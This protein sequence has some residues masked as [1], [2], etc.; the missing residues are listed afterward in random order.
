MKTKSG[1]LCYTTALSVSLSLPHTDNPRKEDH[2]I[3]THTVVA[4]IGAEALAPNM[5]R[6]GTPW[7]RWVKHM[8]TVYNE[9]PPLRRRKRLI[10]NISVDWR[11][12]GD[13]KATVTGALD[14]VYDCIDDVA[15]LHRGLTAEEWT[16]P[17]EEEQTYR[18]YM[19][20]MDAA[21][22]SIEV[23]I[24]LQYRLG[25]AIYPGPSLY[26]AS[27]LR[28]LWLENREAVQVRLR[29]LTPDA[30]QVGVIGDDTQLEQLAAQR[31]ALALQQTPEEMLLARDG[32]NGGW[33]LGSGGQ[34]HV[35]LW[36][37]VTRGGQVVERMAVKDI[38]LSATDWTSAAA[39][40]GNV[41]DIEDRVPTEV[42]AMRVLRDEAHSDKTVS[43]VEWA[44]HWSNRMYRI[45]MEFC[46]YMTL[47]DV[48]GFNKVRQDEFPEEFERVDDNLDNIKLPEPF[49]WHCFESLV[50]AATS[51]ECKNTN[52]VSLEGKK[53]IVHRDIKPGNIFLGERSVETFAPYP[54][55]K[56]G[57]FGLCLFTSDDD[58]F[59]PSGYV[60]LGTTGFMAPEHLHTY[61]AAVDDLGR[62]RD[63]AKLGHKTSIWGIG[64]T[65]L[66]LMNMADTYVNPQPHQVPEFDA[67]ALVYSKELRDNVRSCLA[68]NPS[69]RP[70]LDDL[71]TMIL[72][73]TG[74]GG[75][76]LDHAGEMR[77]FDI[78][79]E[80]VPRQ[81]ELQLRV[82]RWPLREDL[83]LEA[84]MPGTDLVLPDEDA[85]ES[86]AEVEDNTD[87]SEDES[88]DESGD[89]DSDEDD[90]SS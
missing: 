77:D 19:T 7:S 50:Q 43:M 72:Q 75:G 59:N 23:L 37:R 82:Q 68:W 25:R 20:G 51:L 15:A 88:Q 1:R 4:L 64:K 8:T 36:A 80:T 17:Q 44:P 57:D 56:L 35:N 83:M 84:G 79:T 28:D 10:Q 85:N 27:A 6:A 49:L 41:F 76:D 48:A 22:R 45:F 32:W 52:D 34:G 30:A 63:P 71:Q 38:W 70:N 46:P 9:S 78:L 66:Q 14:L 5:V 16:T 53:T 55:P 12:L 73:Y 65:M 18:A 2:E 13:N 61:N 31:Q 3:L 87:E 86:E 89:D 81:F 47:W 62:P 33:P 60:G 58:P 42:H 39:W 11:K 90:E 67:V 54:T 29:Q 26:W 24:H 21:I 69:D 40:V 74:P